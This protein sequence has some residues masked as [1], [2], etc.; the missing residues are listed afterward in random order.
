VTEAHNPQ[1]Q[2]SAPKVIIHSSRILQPKDENIFGDNYGIIEQN[3]LSL[4]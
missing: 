4:D 3:C 1:S 2:K